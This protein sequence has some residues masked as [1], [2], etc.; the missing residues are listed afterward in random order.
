MAI[1][2]T[3]ILGGAAARTPR[4]ISIGLVA[5]VFGGYTKKKSR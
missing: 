5:I 2:F 3:F 1:G 4:F